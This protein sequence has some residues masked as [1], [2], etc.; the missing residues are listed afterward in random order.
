MSEFNNLPSE[1]E[2]RAQ[3]Q[4]HTK[5]Q[6]E[7][8][9]YILNIIRDINPSDN[10]ALDNLSTAKQLCER[11][12]FIGIISVINTMAREIIQYNKIINNNYT[13]EQTSSKQQTEVI[14]DINELYQA[15][16]EHFLCLDNIISNKENIEDNIIYLRNLYNPEQLRQLK[17]VVDT[18]TKRPIYYDDVRDKITKLNQLIIAIDTLS[19]VHNDASFEHI[20]E[21]ITTAISKPNQNIEQGSYSIAQH[22]R[23]YL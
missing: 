15:L 5:H 4:C 3:V 17:R 19:N 22:N 1:A 8:L 21:A 9:T 20:R 10:S 13:I 14:P 12:N 16:R 18:H 23:L 2:L 11:Y 6:E 7:V